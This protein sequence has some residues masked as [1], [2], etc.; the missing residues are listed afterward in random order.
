MLL[1]H[2]L[3]GGKMKYKFLNKYI[4]KKYHKL[5]KDWS[6]LDLIDY[7]KSL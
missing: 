2:K 6:Y 5:Y 7:F 4:Q 1:A 3:R